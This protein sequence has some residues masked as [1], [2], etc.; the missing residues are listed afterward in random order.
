MKTMTLVGSNLRGRAGSPL[1]LTAAIALLSMLPLGIGSATVDAAPLKTG[2]RAMAPRTAPPPSQLIVR[3]RDE[4]SRGERIAM[5]VPRVDGLSKSGG[6]HL[7]YRRP[8]IDLAHVFRF[9]EPVT[10]ADAEAVAARLRRDPAVAEVEIDDYLFPLFEPN[11]G[12]YTN[13]TVERM[14]HL[15]A[16]TALH[17]GGVNLPAAWDITRG[18][19]VVVAVIDTG[20]FNQEDLEPNILRGY[21]FTSADSATN[22]GGFL[23]AN[24]GDGRD[25][26]PSDPGDWISAEDKAQP[27][28][29]TCRVGNSSWHGTHVSGTVAAVGDNG[30]GAVGVAFA[31]KVLA[32]RA[33]GKCFGQTVCQSLQH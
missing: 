29:A 15:K 18:A 5:T 2:G 10:Q 23:V 20:I 13:T 25:A 16:P 8:M 28:F 30:I 17:A 14:W 7:L 12:F 21:D 26:D 27:I 32:V 9:A 22:G 3:F 19:G 1:A 11:D 4:Q 24:D 6:S 31:S 33:L